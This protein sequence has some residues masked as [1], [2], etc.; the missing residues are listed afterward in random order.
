MNHQFSCRNLLRNF[1]VS[2]ITYAVGFG[3][4]VASFHA[5]TNIDSK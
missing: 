2:I 3:L 4:V 1:D 5:Q